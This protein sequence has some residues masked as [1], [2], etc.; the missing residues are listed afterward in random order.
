[1]SK[2]TKTSSVYNYQIDFHGHGKFKQMPLGIRPKAET[3]NSPNHSSD[4]Q[5]QLLDAFYEHTYNLKSSYLRITSSNDDENALTHYFKAHKKE[6]LLGAIGL[7][8]D[9]NRILLDS[10]Q[11]DYKLGTQFN[12]LVHNIL[13]SFESRLND[14]G[15]FLSED[16]V[17]LSERIFYQTL[18]TSYEKFAFIFAPNDGLMDQC[19]KIHEKI[20]EVKNSKGTEGHFV[21]LKG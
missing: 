5:H 9:L 16:C 12:I 19:S 10:L 13:N 4:N 6:I 15:I 18:L 3:H 21:D 20:L 17:Y 14:I 11:C 2:V 1:M 7:V 8:D